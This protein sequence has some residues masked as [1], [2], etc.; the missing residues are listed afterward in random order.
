MPKLDETTEGAGTD[1]D[2][3]TS[4]RTRDAEITDETMGSSS[5]SSP[6]TT[7]PESEP[8]NTEITEETTQAEEETGGSINP[9]RRSCR[10][11]KKI[12]MLGGVNWQDF[13][14]R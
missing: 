5:N 14:W 11:Q 12:D 13:K 3:D 6:D 7:V 4:Y 9:V 2:S 8:V 10:T 1:S